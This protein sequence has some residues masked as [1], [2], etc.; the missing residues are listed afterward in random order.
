MCTLRCV[1]VVEGRL[2]ESAQRDVHELLLQNPQER[3]AHCLCIFDF[4]YVKS[5]VQNKR[6]EQQLLL[7]L[8]VYQ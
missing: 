3:T 4:R 2:P 7:S 1:G 6:W 8:P 5:V